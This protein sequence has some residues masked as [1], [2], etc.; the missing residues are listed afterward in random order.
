MP[1]SPMPAAARSQ[2]LLDLLSQ[3]PDPW[4]NRGIRHPLAGLLAVG[5]AAVVAGSRSFAVIG[6]WAADASTDVLTALGAACG[7]AE[8]STF[9][10]AFA[11]VSVDALDAAL[12]S[13]RGGI[14]SSAFRATVA[15]S[16]NLRA[17]GRDLRSSLRLRKLP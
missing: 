2:Y 17:P 11:L 5:I 7:P 8:A 14:E 9:W 4:D 12:A 13:G 3:V 6:Q 16:M 1:S 15:V 10:R